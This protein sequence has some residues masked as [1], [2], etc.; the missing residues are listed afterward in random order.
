M[1]AR[2]WCSGLLDRSR[3]AI[4]R[5]GWAPAFLFTFVVLA[6]VWL[7][8]GGYV[9]QVHRET[10]H[11]AEVELRGAANVMNAHANRTYQAAK[12]ILVVVEHWLTDQNDRITYRALDDL[13]RLLDALQGTAHEPFAVR[14]INAADTG[15]WRHPKATLNADNFLG[16]RDYVSQLRVAP[17]GMFFLGTPV[18]GRASGT[19]VLPVGY[20]VAANTLGIK[21]ASAII[22]E[23][24]FAN[25]YSGLTDVAPSTVGLIRADGTV[26]FV[27]PI[28]EN[29]KGKVMSGMSDVVAAK[30]AGSSGLLTLPSLD[31]D[32]QSLVHYARFD[33]EPL[34][35]FVAMKLSDI[36]IAWR[37]AIAVPMLL[38]VMATIVVMI[39][40]SWLIGLMRR[41]A[42]KALELATALAKA[43]AANETKMHFLANMSHEL[44]TP[45]NAV[46]GF[47]EVLENEL[48]GP[49]GAKAYRTYAKDIGD[50]GRHLL[51]IISQILETAKL[52]S[53]TLAD[54]DT[55]ADLAEH[56]PACLRLL[57][58]KAASQ[59]VHL[60]P[61]L[62]VDLPPLKIDPLHLRQVL[63]NLIGNAIKFSHPGD[64]VEIDA[65]VKPGGMLR[66]EIRDQ[67]VGI[68]PENMTEL[69][70]P[71]SQVE[72]S[73]SRQHGGVGLGL[74]NTRWLVEAYGGR[75]YLESVY[76]QGTT[77]V[78]E[79]PIQFKSP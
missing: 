24:N 5:A 68:K 27:W 48:F 2:G 13:A 6:A 29:I 57:A 42:S 19:K 73:L 50:S 70:K 56:L 36:E 71:F 21:Y 35:V 64:T 14:L 79:L 46:I 76:G 72:T 74:V 54:A 63:I 3:A 12:G 11:E 41:N 18:L 38:A 32:G 53:G 28:D 25:A 44:R 8:I 52:E 78:V 61:C 67:G 34:A 17:P 43:E 30:P 77:A 58:D 62:L 26:L 15:V 37:D 47:S 1:S 31:G 69:F 40:G 7:A 60:A 75:V 33:G 9:F 59:Q 20:R 45:L 23:A 66:L 51:G 10:Y 22:K 65:L 55:V 16:D 49:L 4:L 39:L